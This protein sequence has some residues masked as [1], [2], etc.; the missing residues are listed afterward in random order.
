MTL[1]VDRGNNTSHLSYH[2]IK[3]KEKQKKKTK[4]NQT[5]L[6]LRLKTETVQNVSTKH[7]SVKG[8]NYL[9]IHHNLFITL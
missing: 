9:E 8:N 5:P 1:A 6:K 2:E 3:A 7:Q 4:W